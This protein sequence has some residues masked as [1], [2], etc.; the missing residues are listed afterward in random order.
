MNWWIKLYRNAS[1]GPCVRLA[2]CFRS[3]A[4]LFSNLACRYSYASYFSFRE[5]R[6]LILNVAVAIL[7]SFS[8]K[9][10]PD[11]HLWLYIFA[12][13]SK[14]RRSVTT[15][16]PDILPTNEPTSFAKWWGN[17]SVSVL[18]KDKHKHI[19]T[20]VSL[21]LCRNALVIGGGTFP[22]PFHSPYLRFFF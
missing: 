9:R 2:V 12:V 18:H 13:E 7:F 8:R 21:N 17:P 1:N 20:F 6:A 19:D 10:H 3:V 22:C 16:M 11:A 14:R 5:F 4:G 15:S